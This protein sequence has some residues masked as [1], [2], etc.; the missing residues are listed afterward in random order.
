[1]SEETQAPVP[2]K[3]P[4][5]SKKKKGSKNPAEIT[6]EYIAEQRA[7]REAAK[8]AKKDALIAQGIDPEQVDTPPDLRFISRPILKIP[9]DE[10]DPL[11]SKNGVNVKIMTYNVLAQ[12]LIRRTLFPTSGNAVKWFKRSQVLL[13]EFKHYNCDVLLLQEVDHVQFNSFWRSEFEKLG[14]GAVF[15]RW[16]DKN[17][18]VAIFFRNITKNVGLILALKFKDSILQEFPKTDKKGI[19]VGTTHLFW[20]P[21]GTYERTRQT[22]VILNKFREFIN[23]VQVLQ[24]GSWFHFFGGDFNAQPYDAP[25]LSITSK[26]IHYDTRCKTVIEC[27]TSFQYSKLREGLEDEDEDGGNI[28]KFGENQPQH[29]VPDSFTPTEEQ[30]QIVKDMEDLHNLQPMRAISLYSVAYKLLHPENSGLDNEK[31]EP[32]VSN[33]AH[34]WRGLLD[35]I[36]YITEWDLKS[37]SQVKSL[38]EFEQLTNV[39]INGLLRMP[40]GKEMTEHGQP[41]EGE[42]PSDHLCMIADLTLIL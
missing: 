12:A 15:N 3:Q 21:F 34:A 42:Y 39:K 14:Y 27:S 26:P 30:A 16:G 29:P 11:F 18:G 13:S 9:R 35:Y 1:M 37:D 10:S 19:L 24:K 33:W 6:P 23:R 31:G 5:A 28:E 25:Y 4:K 7:K 36:F 2:A 41:H 17:H 8:K 20:H 22:Y 38:S 40:P 32:E